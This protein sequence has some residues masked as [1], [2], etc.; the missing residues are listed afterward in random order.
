VVDTY[1]PTDLSSPYVITYWIYATRDLNPLRGGGADATPVAAAIRYVSVVDPCAPVETTCTITSLCS[2][3][4][5][6]I[7][8]A[9]ATG[10]ILF[11]FILEMF[12]YR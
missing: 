4:G 6:C 7:K 12:F 9:I 10:L 1:T 5:Q 2:V 8:G 3:N 11:V